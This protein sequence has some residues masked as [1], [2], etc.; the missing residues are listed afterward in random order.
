MLYHCVQYRRWA[1]GTVGKML[2][3]GGALVNYGLVAA[4]IFVFHNADDEGPGEIARLVSNSSF[5]TLML[6][7]SLTEVTAHSPPPLYAL[8]QSHRCFRMRNNGLLC[9]TLSS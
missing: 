8:C 9:L 2:E 7:F 6:V 5:A 3:Y 4:T 1:L